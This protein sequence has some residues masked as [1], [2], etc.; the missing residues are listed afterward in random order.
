MRYLF[1]KDLKKRKKYYLNENNIINYKFLTLY[2]R[3]NICKKYKFR[4]FRK[5]SKTLIKN[6]CNISMRNRGIFNFFGLSRMVIRSLGSFG[7][8]NGLRKSNW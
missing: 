5:Y 3:N 4:F 2:Y 7:L 1:Y 6:K 8:L